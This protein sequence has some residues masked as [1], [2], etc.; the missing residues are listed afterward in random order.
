MAV[1]GARFFQPFPVETHEVAEAPSALLKSVEQKCK[2]A[3]SR[4]FDFF[5]AAS[6]SNLVEQN[7]E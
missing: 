3:G 1:L 2:I 6:L 4:V 5:A 7:G